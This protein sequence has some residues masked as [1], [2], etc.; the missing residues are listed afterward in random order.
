MREADVFPMS[1]GNRFKS[2]SSSAVELPERRLFKATLL[3]ICIVIAL[4][5][6]PEQTYS[7]S[8]IVTATHKASDF[9]VR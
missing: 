6:C 5:H 8:A 9:L 4:I 7:N 2:K 1:F 3:R